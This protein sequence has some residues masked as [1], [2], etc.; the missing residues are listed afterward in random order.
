MFNVTPSSANLWFDVSNVA[1]VLGAAA[2]F[3]GTY[4]A[5]T[6]G[7]IKERFADE[8]ISENVVATAKANEVAAKANERA[9]TLEKEAAA[10]RLKLEKNHGEAIALAVTMGR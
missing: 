2:V 8:R 5:I 3:L 1:L 9:A 4:G 7:S 10:M 6:M